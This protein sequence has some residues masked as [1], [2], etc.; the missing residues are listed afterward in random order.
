MSCLLSAKVPL[1]ISPNCQTHTQQTLATRQLKIGTK[2][3]LKGKR[4][5]L[6]LSTLLSTLFSP[7]K[8]RFSRLLMRGKKKSLKVSVDHI[9]LTY[10]MHH[11]EE[12]LKKKIL[13]LKCLTKVIQVSPTNQEFHQLFACSKTSW[14]IIRHQWC[15][16][17][18]PPSNSKLS[19]QVYSSNNNSN[20]LHLHSVVELL[21]RLR[22]MVRVTKKSLSRRKVSKLPR[23]KRRKD[24]PVTWRANSGD[25]LCT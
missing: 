19:L 13:K 11:Q 2:T 17:C 4:C 5:R 9:I 18:L 6:Q 25:Y 14:W 12:V 23:M 10:L 16:E 7:K 24:G 3:N 20:N 1:K 21:R 22:G 8:V 15:S